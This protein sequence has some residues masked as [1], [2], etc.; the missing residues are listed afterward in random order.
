MNRHHPIK[1]V[2]ALV[3]A[4]AAGGTAV[5]AL[6]LFD[7]EQTSFVL[8]G[9]ATFG[10]LGGAVLARRR[11]LLTLAAAALVTGWMPVVFFRQAFPYREPLLRTLRRF[12]PGFVP[13]FGLV[14]FLALAVPVYVTHHARTKPTLDGLD[15][16]LM[17]SSLWLLVIAGGA[18]MA[19]VL[20]EVIG[21]GGLTWAFQGLGLA[22]GAGGALVVVLRDVGRLRFIDAL[23]D[24]RASGWHVVP[25]RAVEDL[26]APSYVAGAGD[27]GALV[28][29]VAPTP[30][31]SRGPVEHRV[32]AWMPL[33][34]RRMRR[35]IRVRAVLA[36]GLVVVE[37]AGAIT[38]AAALWARPLTGV[39]D[40]AIG[41]G[42]WYAVDQAEAYACALQR[43][44]EVVCWGGN[45]RGELGDGTTRDRFSPAPVSGLHDAV[46]IT[47]VIIGYTCALRRS[48]EVVCWGNRFGAAALKPERQAGLP[49]VRRLLAG[50][51]ALTVNDEIVCL[52]DVGWLPV[53]N[54]AG[55]IDVAVD[56]L[57]GCQQT[58]GGVRCWPKEERFCHPVER[59]RLA[60]RLA[61]R[62]VIGDYGLCELTEAGRVRCWMLSTDVPQQCAEPAELPGVDGVTQVVFGHDHVCG[63]GAERKVR[64]WDRSGGGGEALLGDVVV[65]RTDGVRNFCAVRRDGT[66]W[67]WGGNNFNGQLGDGTRRT[68][69]VPVMVRR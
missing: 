30:T 20:T 19:S 9:A 50:G 38:L 15:R 21:R 6:S 25:R 37:G 52:E 33:D 47:S 11:P 64:C 39:V 61:I 45:R 13:V 55:A 58:T 26:G 49:P 14:L 54:A 3:S 12:P 60:G 29:A 17:V 63:V 67:C 16:V 48:G 53:A 43:S 51:C 10:L 57:V 46:E 4:F 28:G 40:V 68:S 62:E 31:V 1:Q 42:T 5:F 27:D 22:L 69:R 7:G 56:G 23:R 24:E 59:T 8:S 65:V 36:A 44:G 34:L 66:L 32:L 2:V 35:V 41:R 18:A